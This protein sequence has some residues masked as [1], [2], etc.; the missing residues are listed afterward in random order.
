MPNDGKI[1]ITVRIPAS[2]YNAL[3]EAVS[4]GIYPSQTAGVI[5][6]LEHDLDKSEI[7]ESNVKI[8]GLQDTIEMQS[9]ELNKKDIAIQMI[10]SELSIAK[11][12]S[13]GRLDVYKE[14][15]TRIL[16][17]QKQIDIKDGQLSMKDKQIEKLSE[18]MHAQ[19]IHIQSLINQK[20]IDE[21]G[22][23]KPWWRF[24]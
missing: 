6:S 7:A 14:K 2:T 17:L 18:T 23:R 3:V 12:T 19:A 16:D 9:L 4:R 21:P 1:P 20:A 8:I 5:T 13:E 24:W 11:A 22:A 10:S 15:D